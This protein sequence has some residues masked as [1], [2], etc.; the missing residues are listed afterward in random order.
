MG[1]LLGG[2]GAV[3]QGALSMTTET[4]AAAGGAGGA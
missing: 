1:A 4:D 2:D 3:I